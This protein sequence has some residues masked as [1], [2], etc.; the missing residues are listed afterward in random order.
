MTTQAAAE[1]PDG[2]P[3][4]KFPRCKS[5]ERLIEMF[6]EALPPATGSKPISGPTFV[7]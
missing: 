7:S 2:V 3:R 5:T 6:R 1:F 4:Q